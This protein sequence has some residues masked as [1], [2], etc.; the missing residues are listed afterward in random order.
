MTS[1]ISVNPS[2]IDISNELC[3]SALGRSEK[4]TIACNII[5]ICRGQGKNHWIG[6]SW[7]GYCQLCS[8]EVTNEEKA[9][10]DEFVKN[11]LLSFDD[12]EGFYK[13]EDAFIARL[14]EF[15][16]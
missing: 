12:E 10:L 8:H 15:V 1:R 9:V 16:K 13:V 6:F 7:D 11:G 4:E 2:E 14:W 5:A 3:G